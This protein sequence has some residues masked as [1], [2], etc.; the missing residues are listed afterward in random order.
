M[1]II[2]HKAIITNKLLSDIHNICL[3]NYDGKSISTSKCS[4]KWSRCMAIK[5]E[6]EEGFE[7]NDRHCETREYCSHPEECFYCDKSNNMSS[8]CN[9]LQ[10]DSTVYSCFYCNSAK[11]CSTM[12]PH[13]TN[14]THLCSDKEQ[15][16]FTHLNVKR[17]TIVRGCYA[18]GSTDEWQRGC[19][20]DKGNCEI[21]RGN[22]C[23]KKTTKMFCYV[24][25]GQN[26]LCQ[27]DQMH[28]AISVCPGRD[29]LKEKFGC[30]TNVRQDGLV[31]RGCFRG[32][33]VCPNGNVNCTTC[34]T[35]ACNNKT[36]QIGRCL[37]CSGPANGDCGQKEN[38]LASTEA[39]S[40]PCPVHV[41]VPLCFVAYAKNNSIIDR[42]CTAK[43]QYTVWM[44]P[45]CN[46][47]LMNCS[48][49]NENNCNYFVLE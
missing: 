5:Y 16:C 32:K 33:F 25:S 45:A 26:S 17:G 42:G 3:K 36:V 38:Y 39:L 2:S 1:C 4:V 47:Q 22:F 18:K 8:P 15:Q 30:F 21:C 40:Q 48:F 19:D 24:C 10:I 6:D 12:N 29:T 11:D 7:H 13:S 34:E 41:D 31:E 44:Q 14:R 49:C 9:G 37:E 43:R 35:I 46:R 27:Y 20:L 23:N 28:Q